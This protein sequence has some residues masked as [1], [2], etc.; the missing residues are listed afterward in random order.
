MNSF[1]IIRVM[2]TTIFAFIVVNISAQNKN[3]YEIGINGGTLIYLGDLTNSAFGTYKGAKPAI[4]VFVNKDIDPYFSWRVNLMYGKIGVDESQFT[5]PFWKQLRNFK[6]STSI[7]ELS[8]VIVWNFLGDNGAK[9]YS[10]FS[11]YVFGGLGIS[12]LHVTRDWHNINRGAFDNKS[13][14]IIG[15]GVDTLHRTPTLLPVIPVGIGFKYAL[16]NQLSVRA[17]A[18]YRIGFSDY[19]DGFSQ[20]T[21]PSTN[22]KYYG[23]SLGVSYRLLANNYRCPTI[24]R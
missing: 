6:F 14:A 18:T 21:N 7:T 13:T 4:G 17:E 16:N 20:S 19:I 2:A 11:P 12:L 15:L 1:Q 3:N 10:R 22:D 24:R 5:T 8:S 9:E 23:L